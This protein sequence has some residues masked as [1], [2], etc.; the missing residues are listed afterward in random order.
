MARTKVKEEKSKTK[1]SVKKNFTHRT[2]KATYV[3]VFKLNKTRITII[4][5]IC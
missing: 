2:F 1:S 5:R 3:H 4:L